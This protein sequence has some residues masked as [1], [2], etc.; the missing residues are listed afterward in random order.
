MQKAKRKSKPQV[1]IALA[2]RT[3][4]PQLRTAREK[5]LGKKHKKSCSAKRAAALFRA[6]VFH[7]PPLLASHLIF[8]FLIF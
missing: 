4:E 5:P 8:D 2:N 1:L 6:A 3:C 7:F